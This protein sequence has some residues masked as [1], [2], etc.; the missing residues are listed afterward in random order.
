MIIGLL[1]C[2]GY[3]FIFAILTGCIYRTRRYWTCNMLIGIYVTL[4][5]LNFSLPANVESAIGKILGSFALLKK[6]LGH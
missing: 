1:S 5:C 3:Y 2:V 6:E 4:I